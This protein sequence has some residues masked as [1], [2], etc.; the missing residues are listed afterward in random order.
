M[1]GVWMRGTC[2]RLRN[3]FRKLKKYYMDFCVWILWSKYAWCCDAW[4]KHKTFWQL[5]TCTVEFFELYEMEKIWWVIPSRTNTSE[6]VPSFMRQWCKYELQDQENSV[7]LPQTLRRVTKSGLHWRV[8]GRGWR[9]QWGPFSAITNL[10]CS[11]FIICWAFSKTCH[12]TFPQIS[13]GPWL[14]LAHQ[15]WACKYT[16]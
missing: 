16:E 7:Q 2:L 3:M 1:K 5:I 10:M 13:H 15:V 12:A 8:I 14:P 9:Q 4:E 6:H 11:M